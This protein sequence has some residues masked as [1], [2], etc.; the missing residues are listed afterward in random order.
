[1]T[2]RVLPLLLFGLLAIPLSAQTASPTVVSTGGGDGTA[3][4]SRMTWTI[5]E[6]SIATVG[7]SEQLLTQGFQ[8]PSYTVVSVEEAD[9]LGP[10]IAL[11]PNPADELL[12]LQLER[13]PQNEQ[14]MLLDA[15]GKT[16]LTNRISEA[17]TTIPVANCPPGS[18]FLRI[19]DDQQQMLHTFKIIISH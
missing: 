9:H 13:M 12:M 6:L 5:G 18:Y 3:G 11:Y 4:A 2:L 16:L 1:M 8:Q 17:N 7:N 15:Q 14:Y 19:T 10:R